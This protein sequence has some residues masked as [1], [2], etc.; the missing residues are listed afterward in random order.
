MK[1]RKTE[2]ERVNEIE[3]A[4]ITKKEKDRMQLNVTEW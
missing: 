4:E 1:P 3:L 2:M